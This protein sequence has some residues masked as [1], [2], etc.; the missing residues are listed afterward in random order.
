[1]TTGAGILCLIASVA[2]FG[3]VDGFS[4]MLVENMS[5]G[6][7][8]AARYVPA[9]AVLLAAAASRG[10]H[11]L[12]RTRMAGMQILRGLAPVFVGG[13][14]VFAV[15]NL[16]LAEATVILFAGPFLVVALSGLALGE[17]VSGASWVGVALGFLAVLVVA[18]PGFDA[19]SGFAVYPALAALFYALLQ[20][21]S[22][23]LGTA[24]EPPLTTLAW[25]LLVGTLVSVPLAIADWRAP[26]PYEW[27]LLVCLGA[28]FGAG[29]YLLGKAFALAPANVLAPYSYFQIV[30]AVLFGL[31]LI[32]DVP[33]LWT[34]V[35][36]VM[37]IGAGLIVFGRREEHRRADS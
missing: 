24:G 5:F 11:N 31:L 26:S 18:R 28:S 3:A 14:M 8:M 19:F 7:I 36:M 37:I 6:Q 22:R 27:L 32:G 16:P 13:L 34:V 2:L 12:F 35:G 23:R 21:L 9:V 17:K 30:S 33:D 10:K 25:T 4:K 29:Q 1:M 20:L 15:R